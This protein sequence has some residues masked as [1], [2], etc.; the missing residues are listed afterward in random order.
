MLSR[1]EFVCEEVIDREAPID[2]LRALSGS[3]LLAQADYSPS[4]A[5]VASNPVPRDP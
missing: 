5:T 4:N 2:N 1:P 3:S